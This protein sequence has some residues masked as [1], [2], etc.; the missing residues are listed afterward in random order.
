MIND[1]ID[2]KIIY[3]NSQFLK[4]LEAISNSNIYKKHTPELGNQHKISHIQKV[5]LF[6]QIIAQN[7]GLNSNELKILLASAAFHDC[8]RKKDRDNGK[9]GLAS[10]EIAGEYLR[11]N[12]KN[13]YGIEPEEIGIVQVAIEYHVIEEDFQGQVNETKLKELCHKYNVSE[14]KY[15]DV[16]HIS[17]ILKDADALDRT[18]FVSGSNL[19]YH[20]LRT[21][22]AKKQTMIDLAREINEEYANQIINVNYSTIQDISGNK[23]KLLHDIRR[24]YKE[25]NNG[26]SNKEIDLT[27]NVVERIFN[28]TL[29]CQEDT[30][31]SS[32]FDKYEDDFER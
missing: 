16:K 11:K 30:R 32:G 1:E 27:I 4:T 19:D 26:C 15:E 12:T 13:Q 31:R 5:L 2:T 7:E 25:E 24:R 8:G 9:H 10:A 28:D 29:K 22:T 20:F 14:R 6:S 17:E 21:K 18:R 3:E 23:I